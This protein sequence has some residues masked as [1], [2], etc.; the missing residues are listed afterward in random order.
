MGKLRAK[1]DKKKLYIKAI[2][3]LSARAY[4][5]EEIKSKLRFYTDNQE[6]LDSVIEKLT[7]LKLLNDLEY[8]QNYASYQRR[9][10]N[11]SNKAI[12][13]KLKRKGVTQNLAQ[14]AL[15]QNEIGAA[16]ILLEKNAPRWARIVGDRDRIL[17]SKAFLVRKGFSYKTATDAVSAHFK[18]KLIDYEE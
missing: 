11:L 3:L 1:L 6:D 9:V 8:A 2:A 12:F 7:K 18:A 16:L 10:K 4:A 15:P 13:L 17:K 5:K 14:E